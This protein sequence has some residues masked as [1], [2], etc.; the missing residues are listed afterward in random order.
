M[1]SFVVCFYAVVYNLHL[2]LKNVTIIVNNFYDL[3]LVLIFFGT[4][5]SETTGF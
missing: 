4:L 1:F 2:V 5:H 3:E